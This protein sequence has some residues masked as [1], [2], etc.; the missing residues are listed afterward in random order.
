MTV[1]NV[2]SIIGLTETYADLDLRISVGYAKAARE[3][4]G[5]ALGCFPAANADSRNRLITLGAK[6]CVRPQ[7]W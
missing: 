1:G 2:T 6:H 4:W 3:L 7:S 5:N